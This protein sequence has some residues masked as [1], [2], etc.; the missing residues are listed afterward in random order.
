MDHSGWPEPGGQPKRALRGL[1]QELKVSGTG[2]GPATTEEI[3]WFRR[4]LPDQNDQAEPQIEIPKALAVL[5]KIFTFVPQAR[6][7]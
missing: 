1:W 3:F 6:Q 2:M 7:G 5:S 4:H